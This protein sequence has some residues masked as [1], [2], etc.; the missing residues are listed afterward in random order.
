MTYAFAK[1]WVEGEQ[2]AIQTLFEAIKNGEGLAENSLKNLG[3]N[4]ENYDTEHANWLNPELIE[5]DGQKVL[6]FEEYYPIERSTIIDK[7]FEEEQ[8]TGKLSTFYFYSE[9]GTTD[10]FVTNDLEGKYFPHRI[11]AQIIDYDGYAAECFY[12]IDKQQLINEIR[13]KYQLADSI[14]TFEALEDY[15]DD[16][17]E[18]YRS[19]K[20]KKKTS[21]SSMGHFAG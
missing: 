14:N 9:E 5:K 8:F 16:S 21:C 2:E 13:E 3:V 10:T 15:F 4:T 17:K 19:K 7:L 6:Y 18:A 1:Y 11:V 12:A 20:K